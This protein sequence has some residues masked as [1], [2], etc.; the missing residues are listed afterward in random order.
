[1]TPPTAIAAIASF[2]VSA[3]LHIV[4]SPVD[5]RVQNTTHFYICRVRWQLV[6]DNGTSVILG[7][8][9]GG[10]AKCDTWEEG[11]RKGVGVW[12]GVFGRGGGGVIIHKSLKSEVS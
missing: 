2:H 6:G 10:G 8:T 4:H 7:G 12:G 3:V 11:I 5:A 1:M 9:R